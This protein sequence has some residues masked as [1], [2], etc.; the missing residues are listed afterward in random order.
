MTE[1]II[2]LDDVSFSYEDTPILKD[3]SFQ[4]KKGEFMGIFGPNGGGKTTLLRLILGFLE[5]PL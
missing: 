5:C 1:T 3:V 4:V 2:K